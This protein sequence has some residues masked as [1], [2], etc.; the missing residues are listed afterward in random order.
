MTRMFTL[1]LLALI[2][3]LSACTSATPAPQGRTEPVA[4]DSVTIEVAESFPVQPAARIQGVLGNGCMS[5]GEITQTRNGNEI[6]ITVMANHSGA[7]VCTMI[8]QMLDE[9]VPLEGEFPAGEY[10]VRVNGV[11]ARFTV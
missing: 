11:E 10:V 6:E 2:L 3:F 7:E 4:V 1:G 5:L 8:A 9:R